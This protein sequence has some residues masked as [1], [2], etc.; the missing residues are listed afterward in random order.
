[1]I[2]GILGHHCR[3][4]EVPR[5]I[6]DGLYT[7]PPDGFVTA[8]AEAADQARAAGDPA[9]AREILKL[10]RPTISA[11]LVNLLAIRRPDLV[12]EL[13]DLATALRAAQRELRGDE[14]RALSAQRRA[15]IVALVAQARELALDQ[16][17]GTDPGRLPLAE[18]ETTLNAAL[19]EPEVAAQLAAGRLIRAVAYAGFGEVPRPQLRL[20]TGGGE[21]PSG[22]AGEVSSELATAPEEPAVDRVALRR[23]LAAARTAQKE[24]EADLERVTAAEHDGARRL[25]DLDARLAELERQRSAADEEVGRR[26]L[27]RKAAERAAVAA[28]RRLGEAQAA[29]ESVGD[30]PDEP[31][32][33]GPPP[34]PGS[35]GQ[36]GRAGRADRKGM[37]QAQSG[38]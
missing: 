38:G 32:D 34:R 22:R 24:A 29:V 19:A 5:E 9:G 2:D 33:D 11:W 20:V 14:L 30:D 4:A 18:V 12:A 26:K 8:R 17:P 21:G 27:A 23:E 3:V 1:M 25:A 36:R 31:G 37:R 35:D 13:A 28:R 6:A 10:R 15:A 7:A 16:A